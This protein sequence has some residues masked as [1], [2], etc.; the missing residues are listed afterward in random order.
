MVAQVQSDRVRV[1]YPRMEGRAHCPGT[2]GSGY[3]R[4]D[5]SMMPSL[6]T[7][8]AGG[9]AHAQTARLDNLV[10]VAFGRHGRNRMSTQF[11]P[12]RVVYEMVTRSS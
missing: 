4:V 5:T 10:L 1:G 7:F 6:E 3:P 2:S 12:S 11:D 9:Y 8:R